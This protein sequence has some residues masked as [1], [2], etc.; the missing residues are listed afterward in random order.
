LRTIDDALEISTAE[1]SP[2]GSGRPRFHQPLSSCNTLTIGQVGHVH[3]CLDM[4]EKSFC[5][6]S[7]LPEHW[8]LSLSQLQQRTMSFGLE[9]FPVKEL[10]TVALHR[11][12][13]SCIPTSR[14][15]AATEWW[16]RQTPAHGKLHLVNSNRSA[17][18]LWS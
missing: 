14:S 3:C 6:P 17:Q 12:K 11:R 10:Y 4:G 8:S 13:A 5:L 7:R 18:Q 9:L 1:H 2:S 15:S 16:E